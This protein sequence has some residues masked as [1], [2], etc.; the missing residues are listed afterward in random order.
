LLE[1]HHVPC[2]KRVGLEIAHYFKDAGQRFEWGRGSLVAANELRA[3]YIA[4]LQAADAGD[5]QPLLVF[6]DNA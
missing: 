4:A 6:L 3:R 5:C 1:S 2:T